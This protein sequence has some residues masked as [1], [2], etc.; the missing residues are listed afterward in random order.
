MS[1]ELLK[2]PIFITRAAIDSTTYN[3][4][5]CTVEITFATDARVWMGGYYETLSFKPEH[6]RMQR[7]NS[8][9]NVLDN[10]RRGEKLREGAVLGVVEWAKL[11]GNQGRALLRFSKRSELKS[12]RD[13]VADGINCNVSCGYRVYEYQQIGG[14]NEGTP[15]EYL[16]I[17]W[18]PMEISFTDVPG[19]YQS[20]TRSAGDN[21]DITQIK[22]STLPIT[23]NQRSEMPEVAE[24]PETTTTQAGSPAPTEQTRTAAAPAPADAVQGAVQAERT[25]SASI[26]EA[27]RMAG[28]T[29]EFAETLV[30]NG[31]PL[32]AARAAVIA[33]FAKG[34]VTPRGSAPDASVGLDE[35]VK[36]RSA[37][38]GALLHRSAPGVFALENG[39]SDFR[40]ISLIDAARSAVV[41]AG[42]N[43]NGMTPNDIA[44]RSLSTSDFPTLLSNVANKILRKAYGETPQTWKPLATQLSATDFKAITAVQFGGSTQLE[45]V[46]E[47]GEYKTATMKES[48][49]SF[50]LKTYGKILSI[51]R[52]AIVNDDLNG[53]SRA[54]NLF[55]NAAANLESDLMWAKL[56]NNAKMGD[57][58]TL[59]HTDHKNT[60]SVEL[61]Q[62]GLSA[63]RVKLMRQTGLSSEK[64]NLTPKFLVVPPE[65]L[66]TAEKLIT[67]VQATA[68]GDV[69]VFAQKLSIICDQ[70]LENE[71]EWYVTAA[72]S[73]IDML[74]Y[75]Y[76]NGQSGLYT[77]SQVNF[78]SDALEIKA[79]LDF[80][81]GVFDYRGLLKST[82]GNV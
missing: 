29:S 16:A 57:G 53:F 4:D 15:A 8:R 9:A 82:G 68:T 67:A 2:A 33:E 6:V 71:T 74:V 56:V 79:R 64:L 10:H 37:I 70:R 46:K 50:S 7:L 80:G 32:D 58:K 40:G 21:L 66:T 1:K 72:P 26:Y 20:Q 11:E 25:R 31:T 24:S 51:N 65:L 23:N 34:G 62:D 42:V 49:E 47:S 55:G 13:D 18:E 3:V 77:D 69:N 19:D 52:Q 48:A 60:I 12:F 5:N 81:S 73:Q 39:A 43:I 27:V 76:L 61:N 54:A 78:R 59:F 35:S 17:D 38:E 63:A 44:I 30:S 45:E 28:L 75:A 14:G 22:I 36:K 41:A